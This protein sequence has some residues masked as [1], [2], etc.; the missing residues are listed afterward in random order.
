[1]QKIAIT[2]I[3]GTIGKILQKGLSKYDLASVGSKGAS[4]TD[5]HEFSSIQNADVLIHLAWN[6]RP[7]LKHSAVHPDNI[8]MIN[9]AYAAAQK[10]KVPR[11]IM[12]SSV[13]ADNYYNW[14][15]KSLK[16]PS[17]LP[18]PDS[19]YGATK[20]YMEALGRNY[21]APNLE[22]V[23]VRFG[24]V[25]KKDRNDLDEKYYSSVYLSHTD[26]ISLIDKVIQAKKIKNNYEII[27][28]VS[29][30]TPLIHDWSN[31]FGWK[32]KS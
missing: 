23:C 31:S 9:N 5:F 28:A 1:M 20:V 18:R 24:G 29:N 10:Y 6:S 12:A 19:Q 3:N 21:A 15:G 26:C 13:H 16:K 17:I 25:N 14:D 32:P 2:G 30:N 22:V 4:L 7:Y 27:Y 8:L 11:L